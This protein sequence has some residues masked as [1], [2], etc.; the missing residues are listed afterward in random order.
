VTFGESL[1][2][3]ATAIHQRDDGGSELFPKEESGGHRECRKD[4]Q[5]HLAAPKG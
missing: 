4:V 1:Q 2:V 5:A 3:L